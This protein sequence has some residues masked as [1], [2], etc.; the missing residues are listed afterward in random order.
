MFDF[1]GDRRTD[2]GEQYTGYQIFKDTMDG[3]RNRP[4]TLG[5]RLGLFDIIVIG[6]FVLE[7][8]NTLFGGQ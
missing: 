6:L 8:L 3:F 2:S 4:K 7:I 5:G 1:N